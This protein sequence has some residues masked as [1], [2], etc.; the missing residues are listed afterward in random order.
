LLE[1]PPRLFTAMNARQPLF[2]FNAIAQQI[3][4][5]PNEADTISWCSATEMIVALMIIFYRSEKR[6]LKI[7]FSFY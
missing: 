2:D 5:F 6:I 3:E 1:E 7:N 4:T